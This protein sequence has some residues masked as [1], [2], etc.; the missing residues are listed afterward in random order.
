MS[1]M[2]DQMPSPVE[3]PA[4]GELLHQLSRGSFNG[5]TLPPSLHFLSASSIGIS[6]QLFSMPRSL[7]VEAWVDHWLDQ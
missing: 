4:S 6:P 5:G 1:V 2:P 3:S 7:T